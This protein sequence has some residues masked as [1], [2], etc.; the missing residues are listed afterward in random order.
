[1]LGDASAGVRPHA[2]SEG[3]QEEVSVKEEDG[4]ER[5]R[6]RREHDCLGARNSPLES[7]CHD[8]TRT[9]EVSPDPATEP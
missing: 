5:K 7:C 8:S 1:M 6:L 9:N 3:Q 4:Q 2:A